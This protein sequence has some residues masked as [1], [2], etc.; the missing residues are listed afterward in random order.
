MS[1]IRY[2]YP[3]QLEKYDPV[4]VYRNLHNNCYSVVAL[5]GQYKGKV[6]AHCDYIQLAYACARPY[7]AGTVTSYIG[8]YDGSQAKEGCSKVVYNRG[9]YYAGQQAIGGGIDLALTP[10]GVYKD[11]LIE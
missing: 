6:V 5:T 10:A 4:K 2:R 3:T 11:Y 9:R 8:Y 7:K 1:N